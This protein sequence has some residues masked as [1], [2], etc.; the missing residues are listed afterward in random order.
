M[1][2]HVT[3]I[4]GEGEQSCR[5]RVY[6]RPMAERAGKAQ[7]R[8]SATPLLRGRTPGEGARVTAVELFF[9]LVFVFAVTQLSRSLRESLA[10]AGVVQVTLLLLAVWWVWIYTS[11]VTNWLDPERLAVRIAL[12]VLIA[13][14]LLLGVAIPN[15]FRTSGVL[16]AGA[17]VFMQV[18]RTLFTLWA[19]RGGPVRLVR[20]FERILVW[21]ALSGCAWI[22]GAAAQGESRFEWWAAALLIELLS[23]AVYFWTPGLGASS[24]A[25][26]N[27]EGGHLAERCSLFV[28]IALG[29]SLL[30]T[31][32]SL[33][34]VS[35]HGP[36]IA[37]FAVAVLDNVLMW[38]IYFDTGA[39]RA[40]LRIRSCGD[41]GRAARLAY[42]YLHVLIV[43]GIIAAAAANQIL[44]IEPRHASPTGLAVTLGGPA[45]YLLGN[46]LF[47][48]AVNQR[49]APPLSHLVGLALLALI[50]WPTFAAPLAPR[51]LG[52]ATTAVLAL[53]AVWE[54][55][56]LGSHRRATSGLVGANP[57]PTGPAES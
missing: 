25:D 56:A 39:E 28:I 48:W 51:S 55:L 18:G 52:I 37:A 27:V 12:F 20:N 43:G 22:A 5:P 3:G 6:A 45:C 47:K 35:L 41:P 36:A 17:F 13:A 30:V 19:L 10:P 34:E 49:P 26:W 7:T 4:D 57:P 54:T 11:W 53:V 1:R 9:D 29:E 2:G 8:R 42:T 21:L 15:A 16:F 40:Q 14:G 46:A 23:P 38:W 33:G 32:T 50:A 31:G 24:T 44:L